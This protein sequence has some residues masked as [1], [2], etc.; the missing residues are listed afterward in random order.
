MG[1]LYGSIILQIAGNDKVALTFQFLGVKYLNNH[2]T[3]IQ[4]I[5]VGLNV[6]VIEAHS[7][8]KLVLLDDCVKS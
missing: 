5:S 6:L 3:A 7:S 2:E 8:W 4:V 1:V